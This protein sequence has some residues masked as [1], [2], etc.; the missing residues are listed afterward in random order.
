MSGLF[1]TLALIAIATSSCIT[2]AVLLY[3]AFIL[4][5][6]QFSETPTKGDFGADGIAPD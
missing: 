3:F 1:I 4:I 6:I 5:A 2:A